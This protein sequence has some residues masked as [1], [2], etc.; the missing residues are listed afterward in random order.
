MFMIVKRE[1][2]ISKLKEINGDKYQYDLVNDSK[3][4]DNVS[5]ICP[6]HGIFSS[7]LSRLLKG[8]QC[9]H[10]VGKGKL[11]TEEF[12][13][14]AK[15][16]HSNKYD[17]SKFEYVNAKIKGIIVCPI[18]GEFEM[19]PTNHINGCGCHYCYNEKRGNTQRSCTNS[20]IKKANIVHN[21]KYN[22]DKI[23]YINQNNKVVITCPIHGDF[24]QTPNNHLSGRGCPSCKQSHLEREVEQY[25][26]DN[27]VQFEKQKRFKWLGKQSFDFYLPKYNIAI[28]CQ[29]R[30][31]FESVN[32]F[33]G[34]D[35]FKKI[36]E[37]DNKKKILAKE[38]NIKLIYYSNIQKE[39]VL[40]SKYKLLKEI[41]NVRID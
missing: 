10:C 5:I 19:T 36:K 40:T 31:H 16:I 34:N 8:S 26:V 30:Q 27:N 21:N 3:L 24:N 9:K 37:L 41:K 4:S 39:N 18:H 28:E 15:L 23:K 33:G 13:E 29:G 22:Y 38:H 7:R 11:T 32:K 12:I 14:K 1:E 6:I 2:I 20:F 17:Y 35:Y 25:L